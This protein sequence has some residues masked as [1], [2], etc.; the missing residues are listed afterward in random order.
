MEIDPVGKLPGQFHG[1]VGR[2]RI[3]EDYFIGH[4]FD[5]PEALFDVFF[6][7]S[8]DEAHRNEQFILV[9]F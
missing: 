8:R 6:L 1:A 9:V 7:V 2:A 4:A 5:A 3:D